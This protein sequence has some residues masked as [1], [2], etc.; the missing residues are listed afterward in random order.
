MY[1]VGTKVVSKVDV[2]RVETLGP[3]T[4]SRQCTARVYYPTSDVGGKK[5]DLGKNAVGEMYVDASPIKDEKFPMIVYSHGYGAAMESNNLLCCELAAEGYVVV[6][7]GHAYEAEYVTL[8]SGSVIK[9][10]KGLNKKVMGPVLP[11]AFS[12]LRLRNASGTYVEQYKQF[13][14]FQNK[15]GSFLVDR[16]EQWAKDTLVIVAEVKERFADMIDLDFGIGITGH[17]FGGCLAYYMCQNY[18]EYSCGINIDG[19]LFGHYDDF[20]MSK[21]FFQICSKGNESVVSRS[22]IITEAPVYFAVFNKLSHIGFTD[23]K[24]AKKTAPGYGSMPADVMS[25]NLNRIHKQFFAM[26]LK[27]SK[28]EI[29]IIDNEFIKT[30]I[31]NKSKSF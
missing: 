16:L 22:L 5:A 28:D 21:P 3:S 11:A 15:Y 4:G 17:S 2:N 30:T 9:M 29:D 8:E 7:V 27:H 26:Y 1:N 14:E 19:A 25:S 18:R 13:L 31:V 6:A 23:M 10:D 12:S 20:I 24:F